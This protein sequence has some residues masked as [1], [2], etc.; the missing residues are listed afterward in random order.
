MLQLW[1]SRIAL[2]HFTSSC[3]TLP[4]SCYDLQFSSKVSEAHKEWKAPH[5]GMP[6]HPGPK[7]C[8][9]L[10]DSTQ[11]MILIPALLWQFH[12]SN[13]KAT[14][15]Y[16]DIMPNCGWISPALIMESMGTD[17]QAWLRS[18][19][20]GFQFPITEFILCILEIHGAWHWILD[21]N[22]KTIGYISRFA[23][24]TSSFLRHHS[25]NSPFWL[26]FRVL[27]RNHWLIC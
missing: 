24:A 8:G 3:C 14:L 21:K 1:F 15:S 25:H 10:H 4:Q 12:T 11:T 18:Q 20:A 7:A 13:S 2:H 17:S 5:V 23:L 19:M 9:P 22:I 16:M 27:H 26:S 6:S